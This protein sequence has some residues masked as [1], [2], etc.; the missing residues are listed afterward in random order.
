M[1]VLMVSPYF[2]PEGGGLE[3]YACE[4][5]QEL[6]GE[7]KVTVVCSTKGGSREEILH[8]IRV[9]SEHST[10]VLSNTPVRMSLAFRLLHLLKR[11]RFD[12][13]IAHTPVPFY[14]DVAAV[15]SKL[16]GI[17]IT[18]Y[19]HTG[20]L[21][22]GSW[23]DLL[24]RLYSSTLER[25][26]LSKARVVAVSHYVA[27]LLWERGFRAN[28]RY[29]SV[30]EKFLEASPVYRGGYILFVGQLTKAHKWKNL[31]VLLRAFARV[32]EILPNEK[33]IIAGSG[34]WAE[35]YRALARELGI[36]NSVNF[37]GSVSDEELIR[38][39]QNAR[40][41]VLVSSG[42]EAFGKVVLEAM[43]LGTPV[44]VSNRGEFPILV[45]SG[46]NGLVVE[47]YEGEVT[48]AIEGVLSDAKRLRKMAV[49][50][51]RRAEVL[52]NAPRR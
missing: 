20:R 7:G 21:E 6:R 27:R 41:L 49:L 37:V 42:S 30:E 28:V 46:K 13:L 44:V 51:R 25:F 22:K 50:A 16:M 1:R 8:G 9:I 38:L 3:R 34:E 33:I 26:T 36:E 17:P 35:H 5:A 52:L 12:V 39:Y 31:D 24:A 14:A 11:E 47:P 48:S 43:S 45:E 10:F 23:T 15:V 4:L 19:Y 29:P 40:L 18:V 32:K 2:Y